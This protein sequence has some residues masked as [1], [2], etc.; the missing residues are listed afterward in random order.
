MKFTYYFRGSKHCWEGTPSTANVIRITPIYIL[1]LY[2]IL[3]PCLFFCQSISTSFTAL[4]ITLQQPLPFRLKSPTSHTLWGLFPQLVTTIKFYLK[5]IEN[6][7]L[8]FYFISNLLHFSSSAFFLSSSSTLLFILLSKATILKICSDYI[9]FLTFKS[10]LNSLKSTTN[11][12][13]VHC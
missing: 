1:L 5:K 9:N 7:F 11:D 13:H 3:S 2:S 4:R 10:S 8:Q 12:F 6:K